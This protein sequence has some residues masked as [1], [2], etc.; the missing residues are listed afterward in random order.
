MQV[1]MYEKHIR[2]AKKHT[3]GQSD[4]CTWIGGLTSQSKPTYLRAIH[5]APSLRPTKQLIGRK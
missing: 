2:C 5:R 3:F 4:A 1:I